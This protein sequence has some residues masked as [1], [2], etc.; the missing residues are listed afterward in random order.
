MRSGVLATVF[1]A[2]EIQ[3]MIAGRL[4]FRQV[5]TALSATNHVFGGACGGGFRRSEVL[6]NAA[7]SMDR[8]PNGNSDNNQSR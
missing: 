3:S 5:Q 6:D 4:R 8:Q 2:A 7:Q 1:L